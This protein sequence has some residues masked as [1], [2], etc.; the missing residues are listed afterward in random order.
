MLLLIHSIA[1]RHLLV[2]GTIVNG[3]DSAD[4]KTEIALLSLTDIAIKKK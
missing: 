2:K 3:D 4:Q 1:N